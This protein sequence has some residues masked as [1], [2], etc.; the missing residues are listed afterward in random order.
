MVNDLTADDQPSAPAPTGCCGFCSFEYYQPYFNVSQQTVLTRIVRS[1]SPW[2]GDFFATSDKDSD[3]YG[4]FWIL[5][6]IIFLLSLMGNLSSYIRH[7]RDEEFEF[8]LELVRYGTIVVY[9]FGLGFPVV[10]G[11]LLRFFKSNVTAFQVIK[12]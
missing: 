4:P 5:T 9:S 1:L 11:L 6:T 3:L 7:F 2:R 8:R 10:L 12:S